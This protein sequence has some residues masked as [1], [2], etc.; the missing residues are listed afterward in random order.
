MLWNKQ[1]VQRLAIGRTVW[2]SHP[3]GGKIFHTHPDWPWGPP[4]LLHKW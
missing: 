2:G 1:F 3:S 4:S